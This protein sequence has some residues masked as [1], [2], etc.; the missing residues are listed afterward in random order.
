MI[1]P[2][3]YYV[4]QICTSLIIRRYNS[5]FKEC[6]KTYLSTDKSCLHRNECNY[7]RWGSL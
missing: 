5:A 4:N 2:I 6:D 7:I 1:I 3:S